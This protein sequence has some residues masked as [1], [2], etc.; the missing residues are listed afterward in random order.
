MKNHT[1]NRKLGAVILTGFMLAGTSCAAPQAGPRQ[2]STTSTPAPSASP[3]ASATGSTDSVAT[4]T[5]AAIE[6]F[7]FP[8]GHVSFDHPAGW[9]VRTVQGPFLDEAAKAGSVDAIVS[10]PTGKDVVS[11]LS[12]MYGDGAGGPVTRT[13]LDQAP[14]SGVTT[15]DGETPTLGFVVDEYPDGELNFHLDVRRPQEFAAGMNGSGT[16]Q[17]PLGNGRMIARAVLDVEG[18]SVFSTRDE[19]KAWMETDEYRQIRALL[20]SLNYS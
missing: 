1:V 2:D 11:V 15:V 7:T 3:S 18:K 4:P 9:S 20:L 6:T 10:D 13:V 14:I 5:A 16:N 8:D 17:V 19:A 12:G